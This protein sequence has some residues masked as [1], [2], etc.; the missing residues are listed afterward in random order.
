MEKTKWTETVE[1]MLKGCLLDEDDKRK[2]AEAMEMVWNIRTI[3]M[4]LKSHGCGDS[5]AHADLHAAV[6]DL[7]AVFTSIAEEHRIVTEDGV[8]I[9]K[10]TQSY[11]Q[12]MEVIEGED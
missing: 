5:I 7:A 9:S 10:E 6:V 3:A 8:R 12:I 4:E 11:E 2:I 1:R